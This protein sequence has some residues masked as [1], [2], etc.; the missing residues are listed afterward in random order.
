[1]LQAILDWLQSLIDFRV[2]VSLTLR[3]TTTAHS[4]RRRMWSLEVVVPAF[5]NSPL[6]RSNGVTTQTLTSASWS[7]RLSIIHPCY[8]ST[9]RAATAMC[10]IISQSHAITGT[11]WPAQLT[12]VL[13]PHWLPKAWTA[14]DGWELRL[15]WCGLLEN[16]SCCTLVLFGTVPINLISTE[17]S[18]LCILFCCSSRWNSEWFL[19]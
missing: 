2:S 10:M 11:S 4:K 18:W 14:L 3:I 5:Q 9:R 19:L 17:F 12:I 16:C 8:S 7:S 1:M 13:G 15:V 6:Q